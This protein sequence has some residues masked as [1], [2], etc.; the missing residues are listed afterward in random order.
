MTTSPG[1]TR[2]PPATDEVIETEPPTGG[3][4][5][6][7]EGQIVSDPPISS[8]VEVPSEASE[9]GG[10]R[11]A[12]ENDR[13]YEMPPLQATAGRAMDSAYG[14]PVEAEATARA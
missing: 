12:P 3:C 11:P 5:V 14:E 1:E 8:E 6:G 9:A 4:G 13:V 7:H 10:E 2:A